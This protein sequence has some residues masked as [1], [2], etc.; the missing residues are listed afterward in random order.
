MATVSC[1]VSSRRARLD[2]VQRKRQSHSVASVTPN[3][4]RLRKVSMVTAQLAYPGVPIGAA[5][6]FPQQEFEQ[7]PVYNDA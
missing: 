3:Q 1:Q 6:Q 2:T 4:T 5:Y 7:R